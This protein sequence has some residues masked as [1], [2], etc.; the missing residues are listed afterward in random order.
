[1]GAAIQRGLQPKS[2]SNRHSD[3][4]TYGNTN[5]DFYADGCTAY[6]NCDCNRDRYSDRRTSDSDSDSDSYRHADR[7]SAHAYGD[8]NGYAV[9]GYAQRRMRDGL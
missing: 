3:R 5:A 4:D 2:H 1:L 6:A 7:R 9:C 8:C